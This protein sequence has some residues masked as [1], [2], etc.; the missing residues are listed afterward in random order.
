MMLPARLI[1]L[2]LLVAVQTVP[3][4]EMGESCVT[5]RGEPGKCILFRE[6][7]SLVE[8]HSKPI[9]MP[10]DTE[11]VMNSRCGQL[12]RKTLVC[13]ADSGAVKTPTTPSSEDPVEKVSLLESP[14]CGIQLAD[15]I[16]GGQITGV[17][18]FPWT[19]LL[20]YHEGGNVFRYH[21]GGSLINERYIVTAAHC[22]VGIPRRWKLH[23]VRL[24]EWDI[25][26]ENDCLDDVC[27]QNPPIDLD[28]EKIITHRSY[29]TRDQSKNN[30]IALLRLNRTVDISDTVRPICLPWTS[31]LRNRTHIGYETVA[32]GWG[33]TET[34]SSSE[35]KLKVNLNVT[36]LEECNMM[37]RRSGVTLKPTHLCA[38]GM[39]GKDTCSGDSGGP[40]MRQIFGGWYL[41]GVV[42]FGP[43][44]C[45]TA[46]MPGVY[47]N[48]ADYVDWIQDNMESY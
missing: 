38:G 25:S 43:Q 46:R 16:Y 8:L 6:C 12:N 18:E 19:A 47:V 45:G 27:A 37:Y 1:G 34:D 14:Q 23:R 10:S 36:T 33:K 5:P 20:E 17:N 35:K 2:C 15:R 32:A 9:L 22:I 31:S 13:C 48:V 7:A 41:I 3:A 4:L 28:I 42:S 44:K 30:D 21:C 11:F 24:G 39:R 40:L 29:D 26:T